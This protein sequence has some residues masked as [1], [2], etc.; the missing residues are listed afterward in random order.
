[1]P[2]VRTNI[3]CTARARGPRKRAGGPRPS[4]NDSVAGP[5]HTNG[6][7]HASVLVLNRLY[8]AVHVVGVRRAIAML[9]CQRAEV[10][11]VEDG[12]FANHDFHSWRRV[13]RLQV[14]CKRPL[15]DW[16]AAVNFEL[17]VPRVIRLL[18]FDR[19]PRQKLH[20]NRRAV[21]ARD[22]SVCQYCGRHFPLHQLSVDHVIPQSRNGKTEWENVVCACLAC[23]AKKGGHTPKE[24]RMRL[25]RRPSRPKR[26]P[27][28]LLKLSD[29]KY[30]T[31]R[32]W[33][34]GARWDIGVG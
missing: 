7:L 27:A 2:V 31:W 23:N 14:D 3:H 5:T 8:M 22:E 32:M 4:T 30:E 28:I 19:V 13:S 11:H 21:L 24:A 6:A 15:D 25:V 18:S 10:I 34:N 17:Q 1:M 16:I 33:L 26:D 12:Q 9:F 29:P 20:L